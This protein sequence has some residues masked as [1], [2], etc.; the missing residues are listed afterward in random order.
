[1]IGAWRPRSAPRLRTTFGSVAEQYDRARPTYP[2]AVF[3][4]LVEL[5]ALGA[6]GRVLEIG[7]GTGKATSSWRGA[8][9][10][11]SRWS[12]SP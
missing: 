12:F 6:G 4:D 5:S 8:G 7:P 9:S 11:S 10:R 2:A 3:D 1:M